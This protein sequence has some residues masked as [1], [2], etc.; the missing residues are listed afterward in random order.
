MFAHGNLRARL[1]RVD[2]GKVAPAL[3]DAD[4]VLDPVQQGAD[5]V[6]QSRA[7]AAGKRLSVHIKLV[8]QS[9]FDEIAACSAARILRKEHGGDAYERDEKRRRER[10]EQNAFLSVQKLLRR[11]ERPLFFVCYPY[12]IVCNSMPV[13]PRRR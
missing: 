2:A 12:L 13:Y 4:F 6:E 11:D 3:F 5:L 7:L 10:Y 9:K 1:R 8:R